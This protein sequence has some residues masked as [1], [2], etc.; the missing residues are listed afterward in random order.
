MSSVIL[1]IFNLISAFVRS[2]SVRY[3]SGRVRVLKVRVIAASHRCLIDSRC[4]EGVV[5][6]F[7]VIVFIRGLKYLGYSR[8]F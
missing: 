2:N 4:F 8:R 3:N 1:S 5:F 6:V 7:I